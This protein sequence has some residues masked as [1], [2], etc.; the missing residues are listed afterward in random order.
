MLYAKE[1]SRK[2]YIPKLTGLNTKA[3]IL[4][5][6]KAKGPIHGYAIWKEL[7]LMLSVQAVYQHLEELRRKGLVKVEVAGRKKLYSLTDKGLQF[8]E[9]LGK[10]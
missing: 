7:G 10:V 2:K 8:S 1:P 3:L 6:L 4:E 5:I 9:I